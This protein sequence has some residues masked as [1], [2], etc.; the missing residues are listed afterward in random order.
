MQERV[1]SA[2]FRH[3]IDD[4]SESFMRDGG[5]SGASSW[6]IGKKLRAFRLAFHAGPAN[7]PSRAEAWFEQIE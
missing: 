7:P 5:T 2:C 6:R 4:Q 3:W 1:P